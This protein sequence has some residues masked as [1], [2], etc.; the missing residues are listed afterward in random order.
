VVFDVAVGGLAGVG[1]ALEVVILVF[2][3][4][5]SFLLVK[6]AG[7]CGLEGFWCWRSRSALMEP[8]SL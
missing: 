5:E 6:G 3:R 1:A 7:D 4:S 8:L 2:C